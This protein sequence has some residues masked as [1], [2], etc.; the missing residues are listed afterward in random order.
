MPRSQFVEAKRLRPLLA[1]FALA[2][3]AILVADVALEELAPS[4]GVRRLLL[5]AWIVL[6]PVGG[7]LVWRRGRP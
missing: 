3:L 2:L 5:P 6:F 4:S 1:Y 7:W